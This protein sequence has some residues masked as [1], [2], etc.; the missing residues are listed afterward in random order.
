MC[1]CDKELFS[2]IFIFVSIAVN[3]QGGICEELYHLGR[4]M[5]IT[6][7]SESL[8]CRCRYVRNR[9]RIDNSFLA[10]HSRKKNYIL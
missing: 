3:F 4:V 9:L 2:N 5:T 8:Y 1:D 6:V 7:T 10:F